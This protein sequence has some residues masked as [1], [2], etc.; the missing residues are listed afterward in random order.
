MSGLGTYMGLGAPQ[1]GVEQL[2][3]ASTTID[4]TNDQQG[5]LLIF[6]GGIRQINLPT[7]EAGKV[8]RLMNSTGGVSTVT[9]ILSTG[10]S[11]DIQCDATTA[12]GVGCESTVE[13]GII[14]ELIGISDY[15]YIAS[16]AGGSTL[17]INSTT[18]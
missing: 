8:F 16:R 6:D 5:K 14:I 3:T 1:Y 9:K 7:P 15:R 11:I 13:G 2:T 10:A 17:N 12:Q 18:T 4:I